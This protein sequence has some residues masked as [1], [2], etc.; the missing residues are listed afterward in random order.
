MRDIPEA[1]PER[2]HKGCKGDMSEVIPAEFHEEI[3]QNLRVMPERIP[4]EIS[5][6]ISIKI[7]KGISEEI[8]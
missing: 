6:R 1:I 8:P 3:P 7:F 2:I 4:E 5:V